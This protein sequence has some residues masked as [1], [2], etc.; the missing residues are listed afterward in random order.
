MMRL[1]NTSDIGTER[2]DPWGESALFFRADPRTFV[3]AIFSSWPP[4]SAELGIRQEQQKS[5]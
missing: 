4:N 2:S 5:S 3:G 1:P